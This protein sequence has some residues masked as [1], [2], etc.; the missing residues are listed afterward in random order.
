MSIPCPANVRIPLFASLAAW[1]VVLAGC[2]PAPKPEST[3]ENDDAGQ[4]EQVEELVPALPGVGK[5]GQIIGDGRGYLTVTAATLFKTKQKIV[6]EIQIP[7][8]MQLYKAEHEHWPRTEEE[9]FKSII[10]FNG[11]KLPELPEGQ[12]YFYDP[13]QGQLMVRRPASQ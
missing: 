1:A 13:G 9:F 3:S 2:L 4:A 11:I 12:T 10:E 8:A 6:F 5:Q 7:Q